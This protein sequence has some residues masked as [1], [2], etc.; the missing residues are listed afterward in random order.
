EVAWLYPESHAENFPNFG[1]EPGAYESEISVALRR[2]GLSY[3]RVS[4][5]ALTASTSAEG[6]L[7]V[8]ATSFQVVVVEGVRAAD[9]AMLEAI[10]RAVEAGVP[11]I[12]MGEFPERAIGLVDAQ[13]RDAEVRSRVENLR[14]LVVLVSS[15][16][17]IPATI[18]NAGVTPSLRP[19]DATGLQASV[20]H[21]RVTDGHL[22][23]LF[24]E[25]YAQITDRVRIEGASREVL[26]LD[27][28]TGEPV[29]A[30]L[31]GDVLTVTLPGARGVVLWIAAAPD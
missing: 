16:E 24:N 14:S 12:W 23:F 20:Q 6:A 27:P 26:L 29:T 7:R 10:E 31:E 22:Y 5:G 4:R 13:A 18:S 25:S 15:V 11:V 2:A 28:E 17:E 3:D 8:G 9:P 1:V 19:A 21:R 30:N